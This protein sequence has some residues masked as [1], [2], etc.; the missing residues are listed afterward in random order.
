MITTIFHA[1][2]RPAPSRVPS[3]CGARAAAGS[4]RSRLDASYLEK[5]QP[6]AYSGRSALNPRAISPMLASDRLS[7]FWPG[8]AQAWWRGSWAGLCAAV[9][10]GWS[11]CVLL[12]ATFIWPDWFYHWVVSLSWFAMLTF[13]LVT[14]I[15]SHWQFGQLQADAGP[16]AGDGRFAQAQVEYLRGN[17]FEAESL[18]LAILTDT[19]RDAE[20]HLLL[21]GVHRQTRR[22]SAAFRR[23]DQLELLDTAARWGFEIRRE[24]Q[25]IERRRREYAAAQ[26]AEASEAVGGEAVGERLDAPAGL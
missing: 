20:A 25:L 5:V 4:R 12:I 13:W 9:C 1:L 8:L 23:L 6:S 3:K 26:S 15:R 22:W 16:V 19:P 2:S 18:L 10:F 11:L 17:W 21:A 24:R 14:S 7:C